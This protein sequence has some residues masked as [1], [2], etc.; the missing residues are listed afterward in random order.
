MKGD[1]S[2]VTFDPKKHYSA[3]Y[4]E[5]GR[6][7]T[8]ADCNEEHDIQRYRSETTITDVI[9]KTGTPKNDPGF[10]LAVTNDDLE[11]GAGRYY[12]DGLLVENDK[13]VEYAGQPY[14]RNPD[15]LGEKATEVLQK[16]KTVLGLVYLDGFPRIVTSHEEPEMR[17]VALGGPD[18]S[19]R[20]Q[21]VWQVRVL[22]VKTALNASQIAELS[23]TMTAARNV[24]QKLDATSDPSERRRLR[25]E[26]KPL[27]AARDIVL[28]NAG[29]GCDAEFDEWKMLWK[30]QNNTLT[31]QP[32]KVN[33]QDEVCSVPAGSGYQSGENQLYRVEV[34]K[35]S[36]SGGRG[37]SFFKWS[38][39]NGSVVAAIENPQGLD[40]E[41]TS[42]VR[43]ASTGRDAFLGFKTGDWVEY[44]DEDTELSGPLSLLRKI[45]VDGNEISFDP[46][47]KIEVN[48]KRHPK[49]RRWDQPGAL[50]SAKAT[51]DGV[52][53]N[54]VDNDFIKLESNI[55]VSFGPGAFRPGDYWLIPARATNGKLEFPPGP[56][57]PA[58]PRHHYARLGL[59]LL[60][61]A[62]KLH[63]LLDC[64]EKF[65]PLTALS[66]EDVR[67]DNAD[68]PDLAQAKTVQDAI[69]LLCH[70]QTCCFRVSPGPGWESVFDRIQPGQDAHVCF[71]MGEYRL[72]RAVTIS[73][74]GNLLLNGCG[75]GSRIIASAAEAALRFVNCK[76]V[77]V[78][79]LSVET[80]SVGAG[81]GGALE[82][83]NGALN[84]A[85]CDDV[86]VE[87]L[88]VK[89]G[90]GVSRA[91]TCVTVRNSAAT[92]RPVRI[93]ET[94][95]N[96]GHLQIGV[97]LLNVSRAHVEGNLVR[98]YDKPAAL[99][100]QQLVKDPVMRAS[101]RQIF[102]SGAILGDKIPPN[103]SGSVN[104]RLPFNNQV[105]HF[106]SL[107]ASD[108]DWLTLL[109][110]NPS[111]AIN[112]PLGLL[113]Y[114]RSLVDRMLRGDRNFPIPGPFI[115]L[116]QTLEAQQQPVASQGIVV[117]GVV[118]HDLRILN[119][120][121]ENS[122]QGIHI[123]LSQH[124][125]TRNQHLMVG[126]ANVLSKRLSLGGATVAGNRVFVRL[127]I[128]AGKLE[129][130][131]I[132]IGSCESL[133]V[134]NNDLSLERL[135]GAERIVVDGIRIWGRLGNRAIV[136]Q[137]HIHSLD[138]DSGRSFDFGIYIHPFS[139]T[140]K[141]PPAA[142]WRAMNNVAPSKQST[143]RLDNGADQLPNSNFP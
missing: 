129:R 133:L 138:G 6:V 70:T 91:A 122:L 130:H 103:R 83:L 143:V 82:N 36:A 31:V 53:M 11:I 68:C 110:L 51:E 86:D 121:I 16:A 92:P 24:K 18:T 49:L 58:G 87:R 117:G 84:F 61:A 134:D 27:Y 100:F 94:E 14:F 57:P 41:T 5:Q 60:D 93:H 50:P 19:V 9:G 132:F 140:K 104:V 101:L 102:I 123:G 54:T 108:R 125:D 64:R 7:I 40:A 13:A 135:S 73:N 142:L 109:T 45:T 28:A 74:K 127:P 118:A 1:F 34:H 65:P 52:A 12:I 2:R 48:H 37:G 79:D 10:T 119:N 95:L 29:V 124:D 77:S 66:A 15:D 44:V 47:K 33:A 4:L 8:D 32:G 56:Q 98:A 67:Y 42:K 43:V 107:I 137:N 113:K 3:V 76:K 139:D 88:V 128:Y 78:R 116:I 90:A 69:D 23:K 115:Q 99:T 62:N 35:T 120:T 72:Q 80:G 126:T 21:V 26:L 59:A 39:E 22:P 105:I 136:S 89:C 85:N 111:T 63:L 96:V 106:K 46:L 38:R 141:K 71:E 20:E 97:L 131:G 25:A 75:A 114:T 17:E 30:K 112:S 55:E 81:R